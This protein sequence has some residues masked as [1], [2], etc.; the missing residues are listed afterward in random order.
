MIPQANITA[1]RSNAPW[2]DDAQV[3]QDLVL[4]R[5]VIQL[6]SDPALAGK[7]A[8]RGGTALHKLFLSPALRYSEDIDLVQSE[9]GPIGPILDAIR[10]QLN[11]W[12]GKARANQ[13]EGNVSL[14]YRFE[15]EI[16]PVRPLRLKIEINTREHFAL[17]GLVRRR[18]TAVN[19]WFTGE[20]EVTTFELDELLGT[21]L[22]AL[23]QRR[24][25]RD[26][27]D[28]W[29]SIDR[30]LVDP[31]RVVSCFGE[32]MQRENHPVSR[33]E[34]EQNLHGK[35]TDPAFMDDIRPLLRTEVQY[36]P[37][38]ALSRVQESLINILPGDPWRGS[39]DQATGDKKKRKGRKRP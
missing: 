19:P 16:P 33:A 38:A 37:T 13:S 29:L 39:T 14:T 24:K 31:Q 7:I 6:F 21:K 3:E 12:L 15:S 11:P 23:Y 36:D 1:W 32:Y 18:I 35:Q 8:M 25:G 27:F 17:L 34:F 4:T 22:R 30:G 28:L 26:L 5:A 10:A 9:P 20:A 2:P